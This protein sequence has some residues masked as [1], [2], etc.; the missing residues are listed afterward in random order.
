MLYL[1]NLGKSM[2]Y[3]SPKYEFVHLCIRDNIIH[4][5]QAKGE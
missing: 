3:G 2:Q 1:A 5:S 4:F